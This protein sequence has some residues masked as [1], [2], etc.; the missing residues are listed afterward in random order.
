MVV[1]SK[2]SQTVDYD[3]IH[4]CIFEILNAKIKNQSDFQTILTASLQCYSFFP[5]LYEFVWS[6]WGSVFWRV[7]KSLYS[8]RN[9][10]EVLRIC[11][12]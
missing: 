6:A 1:H 4:S 10:H 8:E 5:V 3:S 7:E 12:R 11:L 2:G 9:K